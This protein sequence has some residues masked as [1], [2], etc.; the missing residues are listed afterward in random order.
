[1]EPQTA[2]RLLKILHYQKYLGIFLIVIG[3][4]MIIFVHEQK[5]SFPLMIGL[6]TLYTSLEKVEDERSTGLKTS[7]LYIALSWRML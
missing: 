4:P 7:S 5:A 1:M 3:I 6:F 2:K